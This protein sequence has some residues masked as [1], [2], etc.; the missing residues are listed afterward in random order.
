MET[1]Q[2]ALQ[3]LRESVGTLV[4][5]C[6]DEGLLDLILKLLLPRDLGQSV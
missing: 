1:A 2:S 6:T 5:E 4:E 3:Y